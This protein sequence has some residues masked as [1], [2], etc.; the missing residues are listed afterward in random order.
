MYLGTM[1][2]FSSLSRTDIWPSVK[3]VYNELKIIHIALTNK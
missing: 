2:K 3:L 1:A